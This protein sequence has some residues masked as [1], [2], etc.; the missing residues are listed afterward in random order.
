MRK[1]LKFLK[2]YAG[3]VVAVI[4]VLVVQAF[5]D[6]SL[7]TYTSDIVNVGIQQGGIDETVPETIAKEDLEKLLLFVPSKE[8]EI[9]M[10]AYTETT[11]SYGYDGIVME[12]KSSV[13]K[14]EEKMEQLSSVLGKPMFLVTGFDSDSDMTKQMKEQ[15]QEQIDEKISDMPDSMIEQAA[16]S[17]IRNAY[18]HIG[19]DVDEIEIRYILRTG[20][21][22]LAL[23]AL[24]MVASIL[25][26]LMASRIGAGVGRGLRRDVFR[27]VVGFSNGEF[28]KFSTASLI[29]RSTNDIQQIQMLVVM[30][31]RM[32]MYAPIMAIGGIW[33]VFHTN[34]DMSWIIALAV[35]IIVSIVAVLFIVVMP[36]FQIMQKLV[37]RLNLVSRE[38]LTGLQV[39]RA[40]GT[41]KHE[42]ER[43]DVANKDLVKT[44]LFVNRAMT[45]MMPLMMFIMNGIGVLI[46]WVGGHSINDGA[47]QVGDM[48]AF[49]QYTMQIIMSFLMICMISVMLPRAAVSAERVDEVLKSDTMIHDPK[50]PKRLSEDGKG[51]VVFDHVSFRYPGADEDVLHDISFTAKPGETTAFIGSTGCGK[52]T[53][54]NLIPRFYDVTEGRITI[55]GKDIREVS[56]HELREKLGYVPQKGIL[57]SGDIASN[58][59][60]GNPEGSEA[61]ML[62]AASIAQATEFIE[63]K[64]KKYH[65]AI[66]QGGSNVSG[67]QKQR[68]S[69]ARAIAKHPDVYIFDD[70]FSALDYRTDATL[71]AALKEKTAD[72]TVMIVAQRISTILHAEQIIVLEDGQIVGKGT[73][74]ELLKNCD[75]YYQIASSQMS[76][77]ELENDMKEV[78]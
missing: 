4:C 44:N 14:N 21:K 70:S 50:Q 2:P 42:E 58:I 9:V 43:F 49:I 75:A 68:L 52:S 13:Q 20:G 35:G 33:K 11:K 66:S 39:I 19:M 1:L 26:G 41:Q 3:G 31:L 69:I 8:Q 61:E 73:H 47:M 62:E 57:F 5:C 25:V 77:Q 10:K 48:M 36:K 65:S 6:L 51:E 22:M 15:M 32:V 12:L 63:Q 55:D 56:Q 53:L 16:A 38:I 18:E 29:T 30:I 24:G 28:D 60:Y 78:G 7:P 64:K 54:V 71:R 34:V 46:V 17:Y 72:S 74:K 67:G 40:F 37:D 76:E 27:K 45:L 59:M 23:A